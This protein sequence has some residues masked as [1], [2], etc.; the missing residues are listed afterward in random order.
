MKKA[1]AATEASFFSDSS[2]GV[3]EDQLVQT[4]LWLKSVISYPPSE[5]SKGKAPKFRGSDAMDILI[6]QGLVEDEQ[7]AVDTLA[8]MEESG[9]V[10]CSRG[11]GSKS[12]VKGKQL[13]PRK[14]NYRFSAEDRLAAEAVKLDD[15]EP[16]A[17]DPAAS[18]GGLSAAKS[19]RIV[20]FMASLLCL[21]NSVLISS[22][23]SP[24]ATVT[25][26]TLKLY[27]SFVLGL[28]VCLLF[29]DENKGPPAAAT[30]TASSSSSIAT[31]AKNLGDVPASD[32]KSIP[33]VDIKKVVASLAEVTRMRSEYEW[34]TA[35]RLLVACVRSITA[36]GADHAIS[37]IAKPLIETKDMYD[38]KARYLT[39]LDGLGLLA[40][41]EGWIF[42][43][44]NKAGTKVYY[45]YDE[46]KNF[47]IKVDGK[48]EISGSAC[49]S[50]WKE[51]DL[52]HK[53][54]PQCGWSKI[55][56]QESDA[57]IV[58]SYGGTTPVG[59]TESILRGWGCNHLA[60]GFFLI[61]GGSVS[62]WK[63]KVFPA[64]G[65]LTTRNVVPVLSLLVEPISENSCRNVLVSCLELPPLPESFIKW[66]L[67]MVFLML[68]S[69]MEACAVASMAEGSKTE[70]SARVKSNKFYSEFL[71]PR[72]ADFI[73][74][75][76]AAPAK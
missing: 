1:R 44:E 42:F 8:A 7:S 29:N 57:E 49:A 46:K 5:Q 55:F 21:L 74:K 31:S 17:A 72:F 75:K 45:K 67:G 33:T 3:D 10:S 48:L 15:V 56:Y 71:N 41:E 26:E 32:E 22:T 66:I 54:F 12:P 62:E 40:N 58:F 73:E 9:L 34:I 14:K 69:K 20:A 30:R 63:G 23:L 28:C 19:A 13:T 18:G 76:R 68:Y 64:P 70:H 38:V 60:E 51:G 39:A 6:E 25:P 50:I 27:G 65:F 61:L 35:G 47:W 16:P 43:K 11:T 4:T 37:K 52:Y 2:S 59:K 24:V 36:A 53:W